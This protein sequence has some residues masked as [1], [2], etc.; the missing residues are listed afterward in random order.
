MCN[1]YHYFLVDVTIRHGEYE[2]LSR[3]LVLAENENKASIQA[4]NN[5]SRTELEWD[6]ST[7]WVFDCGGE[8]GLKVSGL[9]KKLPEADALII[10]KYFNY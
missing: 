1:N 6:S 8:I 7:N 3:E 10:K 4:I 2:E 5:C 9:P